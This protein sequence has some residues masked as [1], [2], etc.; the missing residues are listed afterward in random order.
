MSPLLKRHR[1]IPTI[2]CLSRILLVRLVD[3]SQQSLPF[4]LS[5]R[6]NLSLGTSH[7]GGPRGEK[8][9]LSLFRTVLAQNTQNTQNNLEYSFCRALAF[10]SLRHVFHY[11][12]Y[13]FLRFSIST[14]SVPYSQP[15]ILS[16]FLPRANRQSGAR[17]YLDLVH[18]R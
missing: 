1:R 13:T 2:Q 15:Q 17:A 8:G 16:S 14:N 5:L 7:N 3:S 4:P 12:C 9:N 11:L 6:V 10:S 18:P